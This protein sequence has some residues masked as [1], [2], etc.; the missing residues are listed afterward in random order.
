M[1]LWDACKACARRVN[2]QHFEK[3]FLRVKIVLQFIRREVMRRLVC[4]SIETPQKWE[5]LM[6]QFPCET[7]LEVSDF[8]KRCDCYIVLHQSSYHGWATDS[9]TMFHLSS[10]FSL[11]LFFPPN[12]LCTVRRHH[13]H[14]FLLFIFSGENEF[15]F[16][17]L[18][19]TSWVYVAATAA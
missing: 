8:N 18:L 11:A 14:L 12:Q 10:T 7:C 5:A 13:L 3:S 1:Q 6:L 9:I 4:K 19:C 15:A 16:S 2:T 17:S